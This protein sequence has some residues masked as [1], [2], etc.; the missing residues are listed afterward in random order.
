MT[1]MIAT[2]HK[3]TMEPMGGAIR[4]IRGANLRILQILLVLR[5]IYENSEWQDDAGEGANAF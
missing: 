2:W 3:A 4:N 5:L 1:R